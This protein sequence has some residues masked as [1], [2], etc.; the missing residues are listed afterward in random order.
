MSYHVTSY[1]VI[2]CHIIS[3]HI[4]LYHSQ[5]TIEIL[6]NDK[7]KCTCTASVRATLD[8]RGQGGLFG[9]HRGPA[10]LT[11]PLHSCPKGIRNLPGQ[12]KTE[13]YLLLLPLALH[14]TLLDL[15]LHKIYHRSSSFLHI[16]HCS[17]LQT[18]MFVERNILPP[19]VTLPPSETL[20]PF[21]LVCT[22]SGSK[23]VLISI[24]LCFE[25]NV[26][27]IA[28]LLHSSSHPSFNGYQSK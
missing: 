14:A 28:R 24:I 17:F 19:C 11:A 4:I 3:C 25:S 5:Q 8:R 20:L 26:R 6:I 22:S 15:H 13:H 9:P 10:P 16:M 18:F 27:S 12:C 23:H 21:S 7:S 1:H 2:S